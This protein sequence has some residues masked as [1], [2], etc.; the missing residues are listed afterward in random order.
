MWTR[1]LGSGIAR[2]RPDLGQQLAECGAENR[3]E[4]P[5]QAQGQVGAAGAG[6]GLMLVGSQ[7]PLGGWLSGSGAPGRGGAT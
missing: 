5:G 7:E 4:Q 2:Y 6:R 1:V 3:L